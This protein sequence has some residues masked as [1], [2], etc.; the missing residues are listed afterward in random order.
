MKKLQPPEKSHPPLS[1]QPPSQNW[2]PEKPPPSLKF[3]RRLNPPPPYTKWEMV[4][5][6]DT[7]NNLQ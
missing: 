2:D 6:V 7:M 5:G 3:G 1:Q 4:G